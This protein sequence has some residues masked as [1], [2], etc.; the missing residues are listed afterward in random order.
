VVFDIGQSLSIREDDMIGIESQELA[1]IEQPRHIPSYGEYLVIRSVEIKNF[2]CFKHIEIPDLRRFTILTGAN[3]SGKTAFL[4]ALFVAGGASPTIYLNAA[5]L[6]GTEMTFSGTSPKAAL[7][8]IFEDFFHQFDS[9]IPMEISFS[10]KDKDRRILIVSAQQPGTL[11]LPFDSKTIE[12]V[13]SPELSFKWK[14]PK[15]EF[16]QHIDVTDKALRLPSSSDAFPMVMLNNA[17]SGGASEHADRYS[18]LS[19]KSKEGS[20]VRAINRLFPQV[21]KIEVLATAGAPSLYATVSGVNR[22]LPLNLLSAGI[23]KLVGILLAIGSS[24]FGAILIDEIENGLYYKQF[25]GAWSAI[26]EYAIESNTQV[27][28]TTHSKEFLDAIA[29]IARKD[30]NNY[31]LIRSEKVNGECA[32]TPFSGKEFVA[33]M[34]NKFDPR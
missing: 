24:Q 6:R 18:L 10:D 34:E 22:K 2:R 23:S 9:S 27:I 1:A 4:E 28:F 12:T 5:A 11:S 32:L 8:K 26:S 15:G 30:S 17:T 14:T 20:V 7:I 13:S 31:C 33:A 3:G 16:S 21:Q 29:P 25:A 19:T